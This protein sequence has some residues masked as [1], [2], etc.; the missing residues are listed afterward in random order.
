ML[1]NSIAFHILT[2]H[3]PNIHLNI[4][5]SPVSSYFK[6]LLSKCSLPKKPLSINLM[7][8]CHCCRPISIP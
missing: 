5:F 8:P 3:L 4:I 2:I 7:S 6:L 1:S